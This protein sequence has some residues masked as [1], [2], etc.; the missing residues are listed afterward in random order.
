[1]NYAFFIIEPIWICY[2]LALTEINF[3]FFLV[4][5]QNFRSGDYVEEL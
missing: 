2:N 4:S 5:I 3:G 1:M